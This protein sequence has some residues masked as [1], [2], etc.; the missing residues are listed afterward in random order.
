MFLELSYGRNGRTARESYQ[1]RTEGEIM[2]RSRERKIIGAIWIL[3]LIC[4]PLFLLGIFMSPATGLAASPSC[5][6]DET[7]SLELMLVSVSSWN[8]YCNKSNLTVVYADRT[9]IGFLEAN[10]VHYAG[11][12][13]T[14]AEAQ[15]WIA[16]N[17]PSGRC[18]RDYRCVK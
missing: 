14:A 11:P 12:Y 8:V 1:Q 6:S 13:Y 16:K 18:D 15:Q 4:I 3:G 2:K 5:V 7:N 10:Y 17:C 9:Q